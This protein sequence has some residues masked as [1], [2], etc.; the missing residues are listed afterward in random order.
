L[1]PESVGGWMVAAV[2]IV[3]GIIGIILG[4]KAHAGSEG[5]SR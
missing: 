5:A 1:R 4:Y 3:G 2:P